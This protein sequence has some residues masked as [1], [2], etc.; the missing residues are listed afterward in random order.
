MEG[1]KDL[2]N[3]FSQKRSTSKPTLI[4]S[5][6]ND[7]SQDELASVEK[8]IN[9]A[10]KP[11]KQR[12]KDIAEVIKKK[13]GQYVHIHGTKAAVDCFSE[14][15]PKHTIVRTSFNNWKM[16]MGSK[17]SQTPFKKKAFPNLL[18]NSLLKKVKD[19][20]I[21]IR[22]AGAVV[23]RCLLTAIGKVKQSNNVDRKRRPAGAH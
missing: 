3:C 23:S 7:V 2:R 5:G 17:S 13:V 10:V 15:Y 11:G 20:I 16:K 4:T 21:G 14:S 8:E 9:K 18:S 12:N 19:V 6:T 1:V 22:A